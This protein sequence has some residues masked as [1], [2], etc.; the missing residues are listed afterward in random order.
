[1]KIWTFLVDSKFQGIHIQ[2][3]GV[4]VESPS[5]TDIDQLMVQIIKEYGVNLPNAHK[6]DLEVWRTRNHSNPLTFK[7]LEELLKNTDQVQNTFD[8]ILPDV[9][10]GSLELSA[11]EVLLV[12]YVEMRRLFGIL[13]P[14]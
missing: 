6:G 3:G 14:L 10:V 5:T 1:M 8:T 4:D 12:R 13:L 11:E 9:L 7:N 2:P